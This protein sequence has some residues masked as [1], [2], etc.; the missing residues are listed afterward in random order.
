M[1]SVF[2]QSGNIWDC[3][4]PIAV[5]P[6]SALI[7]ASV[8][9]GLH[10]QISQVIAWS[11]RSSASGVFP[12]HG[13]DGRPLTGARAGLAGDVCA[14]GYRATYFGYRYD[15]KARKET[16]AFPRSYLHSYICEAC[17]ACRKHKGWNPLLSYKNFYESAAWRMTTISDVLSCFQGFAVAFQINVLSNLCKQFT[18]KVHETL[19]HPS[20]PPSFP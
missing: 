7:D 3:K 15:A 4:F 2:V 6:H 17:L 16:N 11:L 13:P 19:S 9:T 10:E 20:S 12:S 8:K 1:G 14:G 18:S 5:I